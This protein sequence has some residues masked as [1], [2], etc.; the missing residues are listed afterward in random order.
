[1][2]EF[3]GEKQAWKVFQTSVSV[4][5]LPLLAEFQEELRGGGVD[6]VIKERS[7]W[8]RLGPV[9][10]HDAPYPIRCGDH[11]RS[12][13]V[14]SPRQEVGQGALLRGKELRW[15]NDQEQSS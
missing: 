14:I 5:N 9:P 13:D 10:S 7:D 3:G 12:C 4:P 15:L 1:M 6:P 11:G 8:P 2:V